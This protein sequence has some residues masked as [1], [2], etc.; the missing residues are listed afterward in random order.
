M[1][2]EKVQFS[3]GIDLSTQTVSATLVGVTEKGS[4][5]SGLVLAGTSRACRPCAGEIERKTPGVWVGLVRELIDELKEISPEASKARSIGLS[6]T[7]PGIFAILRDG[8]TDTELASLYDNTDDAGV[9]S[10]AFDELL[11]CAEAETRN[12][13]WPGNM[14]VGLVRLVKLQGLRVDEAA[15]LVPPNTAFAYQLL[16]EAGYATEPGALPSDLTQTII[17][18]LYDA[19]TAQPLPPRVARLIEEAAADIDLGRL[20]Q[21]LPSAVPSWRNIIPDGALS[22]VRQ[23]LGLPDLAAVSI[24]AGD[25]PLG[26]LALCQDPDTVLNVRGSSDSPMI[27]VDLPGPSPIDAAVAGEKKGAW[28]ETVLHYPVPTVT[29]A[30]DSPWCAVAPML[31]SGKV[32]DWVRRLRFA[33][34]QLDA[35]TE[36]ERLATAALKRR[37]SSRAAP[38]VFDTALGGERAPDWD[39][40]ATGKLTGLVEAHTIGD[41]ALAALEGMSA[42]LRECIKLMESRYQAKPTKLLLAGGPVRNKL[43][44]WITALVTGKQ[45]FATEF[46][47]ASLLGAAML[48]YATCYDGRESDQ[49]V[50]LRLRSLSRIAARHPQVA[51]GPVSP[52]DEELARLESDY[53]RSVAP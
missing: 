29:C 47:D 3:I 36:L 53:A 30:A 35:D 43:W 17:G 50:S 44:N 23:L 18:G 10:G 45:T 6:T 27:T 26:A 25:S 20:R 37:L 28:R 33:E 34:D 46:T 13:M 12:R 1:S 31:R 4:A 48:G 41:I 21:L 49:A 7:F 15:A 32:W 51:P 38:L 8:S 2:A 39:S 9:C 5:P 11:A 42:R 24:G 22:G 16:K 14:A 19:R 40:R 52:P